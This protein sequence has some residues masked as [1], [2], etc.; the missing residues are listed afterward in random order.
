MKL[1]R[2]P[3][4]P[5]EKGYG[6]D[7]AIVERVI[8]APPERVFEVLADG[9]T[10]SDWVV[11]TS[12]VRAVNP[13]WPRPG[14]TL[15][16]QIGIYPVSLKDSTVSLESQPPTRLVV[17]PRMRMLGSLV[18]HFELT[19]V[20][21]DATRVRLTENVERGPMRWFLTKLNDLA[22]HGRNRESLRRLADLAERHP[23]GP[24]E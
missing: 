1:A 11:G 9:W 24:H 10:Y 21:S 13:G 23:D 22:I 14:T 3:V 19:P 7:V 15:H 5:V 6:I 17:R 12:H 4:G 16:Y 20:G 8:K 2:S 18:A